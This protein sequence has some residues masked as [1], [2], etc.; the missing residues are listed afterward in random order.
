MKRNAYFFSLILLALGLGSCVGT[1]FVDEPLGPIPSRLELSHVSLTLLEGESQQLSAQVIASDESLLNEPV[2]WSS[3]NTAVA[4]IDPAGLL[5]AG[6]EGQTWIDV[7]SQT[8]EDSILV[9]V[10]VDPEA[11]ASITIT[12]SNNQL[13]IGDML[14]LEVELSATNGTILTDKVVTWI[15]S[16]PEVCSVNDSGLVTALADGMTQ[17]TASSEGISSLPFNLMVGGDSLTRMGTFQGLNGYSV[18]GTAVLDRSGD[19]AKVVFNDD[20]R[21]QSGPGLYVYLSPNANN[22]TGGISLGELKATTGTQEY[23][24]PSSVNPDDFDHVLVYCQPFRVPFGT[25]NFQ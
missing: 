15:S 19:Q 21:S 22:V 17:V 18:E 16:N 11:L 13:S 12:N 14:Q 5:V 24:I 25:A 8:L 1:D 6:T 4:T 3:R 2:N 23:P 20:F 7:F 10:S 9:T